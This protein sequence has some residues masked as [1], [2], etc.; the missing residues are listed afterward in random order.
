MA[1]TRGINP[2]NIFTYPRG[3]G[4]DFDIGMPLGLPQAATDWTRQVRALLR[5]ERCPAGHAM[6]KVLWLTEQ[7]SR[8]RNGYWP[9]GTTVSPPSAAAYHA[10]VELYDADFME[11]ATQMDAYPQ[12]VIPVGSLLT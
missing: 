3:S 4:E 2:G 6:N 9:G 8:L 10:E 1:G 11:G 7:L 5:D 12:D